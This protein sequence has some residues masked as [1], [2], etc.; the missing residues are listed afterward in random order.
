MAKQGAFGTILKI[1]TGSLTLVVSVEEV[2]FPVTS[3]VL[4]EVTSHDSPS[5]YYEA[6]SVGVRRAE[7]FDAVVIWDV[8]QATHA[9]FRTTFDSDAAVGMSVEDPGGAEV[10]AFS[11]HVESIAR[12]TPLKGSL[13][14]R[15][16]IHPTGAATITP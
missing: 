8:A 6:L 16:R 11:A 3:K 12:M 5:G 13:R 14:A 2:S 15:I 1:N 7:P 4:D 10:M 9:Q